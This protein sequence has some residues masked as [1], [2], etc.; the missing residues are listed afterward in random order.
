[1]RFQQ[2]GFWRADEGEEVIKV[3]TESSQNFLYAEVG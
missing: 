3:E 2:V 1:V